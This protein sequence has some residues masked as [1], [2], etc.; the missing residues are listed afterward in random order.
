MTLAAEDFLDDFDTMGKNGR[1]SKEGK[2]S[3]RSQLTAVAGVGTGLILNGWFPVLGAGC[4]GAL[5]AEINR[6]RLKRGKWT[7]I[8]RSEWAWSIAVIL[9]SG[10]VT[11]FHGVDHINALTAAQL[12]A[13]G[14][15]VV[16][17]LR[18]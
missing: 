1:G 13:A 9:T 5:L 16:G 8:V 15:L 2:E 10:I 6:I 11:S 14:P 4:F 3:V 12:G 17:R 7:S 18:F